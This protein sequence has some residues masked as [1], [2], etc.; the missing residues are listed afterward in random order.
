MSGNRAVWGRRFVGGI[1]K[2]AQRERERKTLFWG[3]SRQGSL[4]GNDQES[5]QGRLRV[6]ERKQAQAGDEA[7]KGAGRL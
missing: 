4:G 1:P 7:A 2:D 3:G 6:Q 5:L